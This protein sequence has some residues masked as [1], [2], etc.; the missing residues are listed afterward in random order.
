MDSKRDKIEAAK[1]ELESRITAFNRCLVN[2][3]LDDCVLT[4]AKS[5][6]NEY[7]K[8]FLGTVLYE[9][10]KDQSFQLHQ[11]AYAANTNSLYFVLEYA[12]ALHRKGEFSEAAKLYEK[13][14]NA[15]P[16]DY[17]VHVWL[18]D[19]YINLGDIN[20]SLSNWK[21]GNHSDNHVG[22][23]FAIHT[24]YGRADQVKMRNNYRKEIAK[25]NLQA[26][27]PLISLDM[28]WELDWWNTNVQEYFLEEDLHLAK[29]KLDQNG[30]DYKT[31]QTY[32]TIKKLSKSSDKSDAIKSLLTENKLIIGSYPLPA[33]GKI[34]SDML[35]I[36][37][38]NQI[39]SENDFYNQRGD[40][41]LQLA[42]KTKDIEILNIYAYLQ[43]TAKGEVD[44]AIDHSGWV[45]FKD[46]R[47]AIS[48]FIGKA[49]K[50]RYDDPELAQ[51]LTDFPNSAKLL[52]VKLNCA[53]IEN[54]PLQP[55]LTELIKLEFKTL[56]SDQSR[57]SYALKSYFYYLEHEK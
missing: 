36:C 14:S 26:F 6:K 3:D 45:N 4:L 23:D 54:K 50:N 9:I 16:E 41:L 48:Y 22:F 25:G 35:R 55:I 11:E 42:E 15:K 19:C 7:E 51:A 20:R 37:F 31:L 34:A 28:T 52:W 21:K 43:A 47:F 27:Y 10:D 13:Y 57:Y 30:I 29:N 24:V 33:N 2:S 53:K 56:G 44:P 39:L 46:E 40:E 17:R 18:A 38:V 49:D 5:A 12:L 1:K 32:V 8:Y